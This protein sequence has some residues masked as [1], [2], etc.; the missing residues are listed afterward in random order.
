MEL[1][2]EEQFAFLEAQDK[3]LQASV[4][5]E[6]DVEDQN[7][8][9][10]EEAN[11][12]LAE[13]GKA[14]ESAFKKAEEE[15]TASEKETQELADKEA[16]EAEEAGIQVI[17]PNLVIELREKYPNKSSINK[18]KEVDVVALG[19]LLSLDVDID[20]SA[21][22]NKKIVITYFTENIWKK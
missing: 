11:K 5:R 7:K 15:I 17:D 21:T 10:E 13:L 22:V 20:L 2:I 19:S 4:L 9:I 3:E 12:N 6:E 16:K 14:N 8:S 18:L 1:T